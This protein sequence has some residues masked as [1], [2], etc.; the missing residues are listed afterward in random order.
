M[1]GMTILRAKFDGRVLIPEGSVD[2][3]MDRMLEVHVEPVEPTEPVKTTLQRLADLA[4]NFPSN[5]NSATDAAAQH[6]H[7][8]YGTPKR[9][10][11]CYTVQPPQRATGSRG[12][13]PKRDPCMF[14]S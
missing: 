6:D 11:P 9:R 2:L 5:P 8:L 7:Y 13:D 1:L 14:P 3:P 4:R 12:R 10:D